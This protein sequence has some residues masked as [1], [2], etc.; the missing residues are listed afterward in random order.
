MFVDNRP[1]LGQKLIANMYEIS[2]FQKNITVTSKV[3]TFSF[4]SL[5]FETP[6][7]RLNIHSFTGIDIIIATTNMA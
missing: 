5:H 4:C 6:G 1:F 3:I 7:T 2:K